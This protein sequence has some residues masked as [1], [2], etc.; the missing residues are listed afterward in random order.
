MQERGKVRTKAQALYMMLKLTEMCMSAWGQVTTS[1]VPT[2]NL[3]VFLHARP[4]ISWPKTIRLFGIFGWFVQ[5]RVY[6][7]T[8]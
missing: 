3:S 1:L 4:P 8:R 5:A 2:F 7:R 6:L